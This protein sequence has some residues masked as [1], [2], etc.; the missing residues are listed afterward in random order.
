MRA[1]TN[2]VVPSTDFFEK[3]TVLESGM[4]VAPIAIEINRDTRDIIPNMFLD[5]VAPMA[6]KFSDFSRSF[7]EL[8]RGQRAATLAN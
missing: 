1:D 6:P 7:P 4:K 2:L 3:W 5:S 8:R